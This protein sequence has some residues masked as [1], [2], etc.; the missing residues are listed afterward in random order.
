MAEIKTLCRKIKGRS[1]SGKI[2]EKINDEIAPLPPPIIQDEIKTLIQDFKSLSV[3][4]KDQKTVGWSVE[5]YRRLYWL[6]WGQIDDGTGESNIKMVSYIL[7]NSICPPKATFAYHGTS[8]QC[9]DVIREFGLDSSMSPITHT[10][11]I[12]PAECTCFSTDFYTALLWAKASNGHSKIVYR[13]PVK[14]DKKDHT[15]SADTNKRT[16]VE[17]L[18][19][20]LDGQG[21][22][23]Y[24]VKN[25]S[26][27]QIREH[28]SSQHASSQTSLRLSS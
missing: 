3:P 28:Q 10:G 22:I 9:Y 24:K 1:L 15:D 26:L 13:R 5:T 7:E 17:D 18:E 6:G 12:V 16:P 20:C 2:L 21:R 25:Y 11:T 14:E 8:T 23:W 19:C 4:D 27:Q